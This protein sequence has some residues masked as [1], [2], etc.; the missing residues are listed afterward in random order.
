MKFNIFKI[1]FYL[2]I[3]V[4]NIVLTWLMKMFKFLRNSLVIIKYLKCRSVKTKKIIE[5]EYN[6]TL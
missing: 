4:L 5:N 6:N 3:Q 1:I 2:R